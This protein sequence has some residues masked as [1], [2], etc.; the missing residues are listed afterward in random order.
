M[1]LKDLAKNGTVIQLIAGSIATTIT[2]LVFVFTSFDTSA[3][4]NEK[5]DARQRVQDIINKNNEDNIKEIK[6]A[7]IRIENKLNQKL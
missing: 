5:L 1:D 3:R 7:L 4:T 2:I 6:D